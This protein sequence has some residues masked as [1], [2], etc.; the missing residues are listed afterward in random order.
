M[1]EYFDKLTDA[2][3]LFSAFEMSKKGSNWKGSVQ[4]YDMHVL[5]NIAETR[6]AL[7]DGTY[8]QHPF[9]EFTLNERG[10]TRHIKSIHIADRVVQR[11]LCDQV[12][13]PALEPYLIHDNGAS[14]KG[15]GISF[16]RNRLM[17]HLQRF[18]RKHGDNGYILKLDFSKFF[19]NIDHEL[20]IEAISKRI[21]DPQIMELIRKVV[22]WFKIDV[23]AYS[24]EEI[25]EFETKPFDSLTARKSEEGKKFLRRSFGIGSQIS[26]LVGIYFPSPIDHLCKEKHRCKYYG[27]YMDDIYIIHEDKEFL[28]RVLAEICE[29]A[30]ELKLFINPKKTTITPLKD[31]FTFM[32]IR[33]RL[34][35]TGKI[36]KR[37]MP[38]AFTRERRRLQKYRGLLDK[39]RM[40]RR[41]IA[42][43]YQSFRGNAKDFDSHRSLKRLDE[44][45]N[46]LFVNN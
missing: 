40:T 44:I 3:S 30:K 45:Y 37:M 24:D 11:A 8:Q 19:D 1:A 5:L 43:N 35:P 14:V 20:A 31:G 46:E 36:I 28:Q 16:T 22:D 12:L 15:K 21:D 34:T 26:Q 32:K 23:S 9:V 7:R 41:E 18:F 39:G 29:K 4:N 13:A 42:N 17:C 2:S 25:K 33:Y 27:R 6:R 38:D 10:K